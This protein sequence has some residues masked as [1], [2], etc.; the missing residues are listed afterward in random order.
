[1][2]RPLKTEVAFGTPWFQVLGKTMRDG[3]EPYY[4]LKLPDYSAVVALTPDQRVLIVRQYRPAVEHDT[5]EL[6]SGLVDP[7][8]TPGET[9][10]RELLEETGYEAGEVQVLGAMEPDTGR[11][12]NRIWTCLAKD[13]RRAGGRAPEEGITVLAWTLEELSQAL[14]GGRF[15]HALHVAV[16]MMAVMKGGLKLPGLPTV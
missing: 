3:E 11:L 12:G 10:G 9:A 7:G 4:S 5:L 8:E 14:A 15:D 13:V 6:P 16:L 2:K 1:M